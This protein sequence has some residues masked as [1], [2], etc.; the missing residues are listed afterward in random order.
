[1]IILLWISE[2][3]FIVILITIGV[4]LVAIRDGKITSFEQPTLFSVLQE[5][6]D[7]LAILL[8]LVCRNSVKFI[9]LHALLA[10]KKTIAFLRVKLMKVE[11]RF[12]KQIDM[13]HGKGSVNKKNTVSFYLREIKDH[14][15]KIK[16]INK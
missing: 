3:S 16:G 7:W 12:A 9:S 1:M 15:D 6:I 5:K 10:L 4:R 14:S 8:V 2:L 13:V 11:K